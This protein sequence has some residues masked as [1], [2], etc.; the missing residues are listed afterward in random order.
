MNWHYKLTF[1][2]SFFFTIFRAL[3]SWQSIGL[4]FDSSFIKMQK[5]YCLSQLSKMCSFQQITFNVS[6]NINN[7]CFQWGLFFFF[8]RSRHWFEVLR[9]KKTQHTWRLCV[10]RSYFYH[11]SAFVFVFY[12]ERVREHFHIFFSLMYKCRADKPGVTLWVK[13]WAWSTV[14][15]KL[16]YFKG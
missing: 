11:W 2:S 1:I 4:S 15:P 13:N 10:K 14:H 6:E 3:C 9:R 16:H 8:N 12:L 5:M 7:H